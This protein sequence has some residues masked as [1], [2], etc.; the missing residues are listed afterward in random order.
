MRGFLAHERLLDENS[1]LDFSGQ[2]PPLFG[3][4]RFANRLENERSSLRGWCQ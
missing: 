3:K 2:K 4:A 1:E